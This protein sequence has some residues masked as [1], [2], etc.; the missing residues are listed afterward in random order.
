M[1]Y[2]RIHRVVEEYSCDMYDVVSK[3]HVV[4]TAQGRE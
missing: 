2:V 1:L 4:S 3:K